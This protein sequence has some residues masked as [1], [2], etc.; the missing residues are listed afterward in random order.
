MQIR[1]PVIFL[2]CLL[3]GGCAGLEMTRPI[4]VLVEG[5]GVYSRPISTDSAKAQQ[6]FDQGLRLT[7]GYHFPEAV[8]SYQEALRHDLSNPMIYWGL[9]LALGPNP[10]SRAA[11]LP[12]DPQGEARRAIAKGM[13]L[14]AAATDEE[15]AFIEALYVR[16]D[17]ESYPDP[18]ERDRAYQHA[19]QSVFER[20][21]KDPDAGA[22][23]ADAHMVTT[24]WRY[25]GFDGEP[26]PGTSAAAR[27]LQ[28]V[29][30]LRPDH[31]GANHLYIHLMESSQTPERALPSADRL[32]SLMPGVG[33]VVHMPGHI[34]I[35]VGQHSKSVET[36]RRSVAADTA[37]LQAWGD[38]AFPKIGTYFLSA[39]NHRRHAYDFIRYSSV[40]Q[41]NY[42][43][44]LQAA[45]DAE[46]QAGEAMILDGPG[47]TLVAARWLVPKIFGRWDDL[48]AHKRVLEGE[49][50]LDGMWHYTQGSGH[51]GRGEIESAVESLHAL[52]D[53]VADPVAKS[54]RRNRND[55]A[56]LMEIAAHGLE[57]EI[58]EAQGNVDAAIA[59]FEKAVAI[60]D[61]LGYREP[62]DWS[63][64]MRQ[65]LGAALLAAGRP[66]EAETVYREDLR[67]NRNNGWSLFGMW[68]SLAAQGNTEEAKIAWKTFEDTWESADVQLSRSRF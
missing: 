3:L 43:E 55:V 40:V 61:R 60:E 44:A 32:A 42:A 12:D 27:A 15:R 1:V 25:W 29:I 56:T 17:S 4:A 9:A 33:H 45:I 52:R 47:Q 36:N 59:V 35:R 28:H 57:G 51:V 41:G 20:Y 50:Y 46:L 49:L 64:P 37:F 58:M 65:Y 67:R 10:N 66:A 13:D 68:Q 5:T 7:W 34:Y 38:H 19:A 14:I 30:E 23:V 8:A 39:E 48:Q 24:P 21:P 62:P 11:E 54:I 16:F 63:Q 22:L 2:F 6:F 53:I 31:P 18:L 26:M